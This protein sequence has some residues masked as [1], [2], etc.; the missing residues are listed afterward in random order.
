MKLLVL[1][2][3]LGLLLLAGLTQAAHLPDENRHQ[4]PPWDLEPMISCD[5]EEGAMYSVGVWC[6]HRQ[7]LHHIFSHPPSLAH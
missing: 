4:H 3:G 1:Q 6:G 7:V 2:T 5:D